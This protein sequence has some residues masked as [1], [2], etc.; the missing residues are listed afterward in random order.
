METHE[1]ELIEFKERC[2]S[3]TRRLDEHDKQIKELSNVYIALTKVDN[4]VTNVEKDVSEMKTD[5]KEIKDKPSKRWEKI[6]LSTIGALV[7]GGI[8]VLIGLIVK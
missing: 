3:N 6:V 4:K 7:S 5:L 1:K 2:K 8:G